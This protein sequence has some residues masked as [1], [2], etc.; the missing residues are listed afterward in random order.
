M[1]LHL[2]S[3]DTGHFSKHTT[4]AKRLGSGTPTGGSVRMV[5]QGVT[6]ANSPLQ[7]LQPQSS[8]PAAFRFDLEEAD[9]R[10]NLA[11][12]VHTSNRSVLGSGT[13]DG[14]RNGFAFS[15]PRPSEPEVHRCLGKSVS[16]SP[17]YSCWL[18]PFILVL[19]PFTL[20]WTRIARDPDRLCGQLGLEYLTDRPVFLPRAPSS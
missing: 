1:R 6:A 19:D 2:G 16:L 8:P 15:Y 3:T 20:F 11:E 7:T 10:N 13:L 18:S 9:S 5:S 14:Q 4:E 17:S 12:Q